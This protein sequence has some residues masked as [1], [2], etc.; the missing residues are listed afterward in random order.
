MSNEQCS[1]KSNLYLLV[2]SSEQASYC[3]LSDMPKSEK[4]T[5]SSMM[6]RVD[7]GSNVMLVTSPSLLHD[8]VQTSNWIGSTGGGTAKTTHTGDLHMLLETHNKQTLLL[9]K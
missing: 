4:L 3:A 2:A 5:M 9:M 6:M 8:V 1:K 7:C